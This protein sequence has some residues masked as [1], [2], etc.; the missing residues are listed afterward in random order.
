MCI[1]SSQGIEQLRSTFGSIIILFSFN[2][3]L[4]KVA[5]RSFNG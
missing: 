1:V 3:F 2:L 5:G 4:L